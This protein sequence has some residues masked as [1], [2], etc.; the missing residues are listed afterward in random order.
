[1]QRVTIPRL[2]VEVFDGWGFRGRQATIINPVRSLE[3]FGFENNISS[4]RIYKGASFHSAPIYKAIFYEDNDFHGRKLALGPGIYPN[5]HDVAYD[6]GDRISSVTFGP[7]LDT[8]GPEWGSVPVIIELHRHPDFKGFY[9]TVLRDLMNTEEVGLSD[10]ITS[11]RIYKGPDCPGEGFRVILYRR[12]NF[13]GESLSIEISQMDYKKEIPDLRALPETIG[14]VIS[15]VKI[16]AWTSST[17][18]SEIVFQDE[19]DRGQMRKEWLLE[20]RVGGFLW[21]QQQGYAEFK[22][23]T[24]QDLYHE[25]NFDAPRLTQEIIGDFAIETRM[26]VKPESQEY[27]GLL[28]WKGQNRFLRFEKTSGSDAFVGDLRFERH[29]WRDRHFI[30]RVSELRNTSSLYMRLE[31]RGQIFNAYASA[32]GINWLDCGTDIMGVGD[33]IS[34]GIYG[35][36]PGEVPAT[37]TQFD[38][39]RIMRRSKEV[40]RYRP[41]QA[42]EQ[43]ITRTK[44][45]TAIREL[46]R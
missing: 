5:I 25:T 14:N 11:I 30:K 32:N 1:M 42:R 12:P 26:N 44:R 40:T 38:Y 27:G 36:A 29:F 24:G 13:E 33:P 10:A 3:E 6:F 18:F 20:D 43:N 21:R 2:I 9:A 28:V 4:M 15:S 16:E 46:T 31:R 39:F 17:E 19:F 35:L 37:T 34:V 8:P 22:A 23:E 7:S 45:A 41:I